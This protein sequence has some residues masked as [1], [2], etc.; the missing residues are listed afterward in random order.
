MKKRAK[1]QHNISYNMRPS[2][3]QKYYL[4]N[5][6]VFAAIALMVVILVTIAGFYRESAQTD[7][8]LECAEVLRVI[9]GDTIVVKVN[10]QE[11]Y[12]RMIGIDAPESVSPEE[13]DNSVYGELAAEYT[14]QYL[15][16][17]LRIYLTYDQERK[18][19]YDRTLAYI[20]LNEDIEDINNLYQKQMVEDGFAFAI[21]FEPNTKYWQVL[22]S[23]MQ[24]AGSNHKGLWNDE[25]FYNQN[26]HRL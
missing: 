22:N 25:N 24:E 20:W 19:M 23:G 26:Q 17:G 2:R 1:I 13:N 4:K 10:G 18:D 7:I 6:W 16:N 8:N 5:Q 3:K 21:K 9:D 11:E 12:I 15:E 14:S